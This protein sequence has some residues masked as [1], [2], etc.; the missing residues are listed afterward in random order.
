MPQLLAVLRDRHPGVRAVVV[1][2]S[3]TSLL[4]QL[5]GG[6][7]DLA[8]VNL[9]VDDPDLVT[10]P[11]FAEDLI[12]LVPAGHPLF[13]VEE[14]SLPELAQHRLVLPAPGTALRED[15]EDEARRAGVTLHPL[16]E[17]DGMRLLASLAFEAFGAAV[18][19]ATA[20]PGWLKGPFRRVR[21]P[22]L[23]RR[24]V[25]VARRRRA[26][27]PAPARAVEE[28][29]VEVVRERGPRQPGVSVMASSDPP[30]RAAPAPAGPPASAV[31]LF[32]GSPP[33]TS[34]S[35]RAD[36]A[37]AAPGQ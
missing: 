7:L 16:A 29:L 13:S 4:P 23:P 27:L 6:Q 5:V 18:V 10:D 11:L 35:G 3:T 25:G 19:P 31:A 22:G 12:A 21:V 8:I 26:V 20:V 14:I 28:L 33:T 32:E 36:E 24:L 1:E 30:A 15:L 2:A 17:V 37:G 9:P 34:A